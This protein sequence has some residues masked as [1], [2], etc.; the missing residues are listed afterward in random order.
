MSSTRQGASI[1]LLEMIL[2]WR[3]KERTTHQLKMA[4]SLARL[5]WRCDHSTEPS[6]VNIGGILTWRTKE[7][8]ARQLELA[9]SSARLTWMRDHLAELSDVN[10]GGVPN[11]SSPPRRI[12]NPP[13]VTTDHRLVLHLI[14][15]HQ[16]HRQ[17]SNG[18]HSTNAGTAAFQRVVTSPHWSRQAC[19]DHR[20][21]LHCLLVC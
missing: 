13:M 16:S 7:R 14:H 21:A 6:D 8:T 12:G 5:M 20:L 15:G 19:H 18:P 3:K 9:Q 1:P 11:N 2:T 4:Q 10:I 17:S